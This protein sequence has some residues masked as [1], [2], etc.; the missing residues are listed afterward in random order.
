MCIADGIQQ[1]AVTTH[2]TERLRLK[3]RLDALAIQLG[4]LLNALRVSLGVGCRGGL[5]LA[6]HVP[7]GIERTEKLVEAS[8]RIYVN[9]LGFKL[10][11]IFISLLLSVEYVLA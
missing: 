8:A 6:L 11:S 3:D 2:I 7:E 9:L 1:L 4:L 5:R 10:H